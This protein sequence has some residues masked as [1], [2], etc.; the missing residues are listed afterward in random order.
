MGYPELTV[1]IAALYGSGQSAVLASDRM[2][3][4]HI[5]MGYEFERLEDPKILRLLDERSIYVLFA[6]DVLR[7]HEVLEA[8][9]QQLKG[10]GNP[11]VSETTEVIRSIY[12][13]IRRTTIVHKEIEPRGLTLD[14]FKE[15]QQQLHPTVVQVIDQA[16][17]N[18]DLGV[19]ILVAGANEENYNIYTVSNPGT[20]T[21]HRGIGYGAIGSGA[22]HALVSFIEKSYTPSMTREEVT[23]IVKGAKSRSEVAPGV[24]EATTILVIPDKGDAGHD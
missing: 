7:G 12:Q 15:T 20:V 4:A 13:E 19:E 11:S 8:T 2:V 24:G 14:E 1:C 23:E 18:A 10:S 6:G 9:R 5:P 22:P 16:L 21:D 17:A 3:T